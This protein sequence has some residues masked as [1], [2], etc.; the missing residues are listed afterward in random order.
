M[1]P[2]QGRTRKN[3]TLKSSRRVHRETGLLHVGL[4]RAPEMI[5]RFPKSLFTGGFVDR[6]AA[7]RFGGEVT[8]PITD[9]APMGTGYL[10]VVASRAAS[11]S[12]IQLIA[13]NGRA[14]P[15][16]QDLPKLETDPGGYAVSP[17][18]NGKFYG[19]P[20]GIED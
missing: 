11:I 3:L 1:S 2:I 19:G 18:Q 7:I 17:I 8:A 16:T 5:G 12:N 15:V 20:H 13:Q 10:P 6:A 4:N 9:P 14:S